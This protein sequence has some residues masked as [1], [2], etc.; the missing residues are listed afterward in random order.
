MIGRLCYIRFGNIPEI[1]FS[2]NWLKDKLEEG[3][4]CYEAVEREGVYS[5]LIPSLTGNT[6]VG[7][8]AVLDRPMYEIIGTLV[9]YGSDNEPLLLN[10][11]IIKEIFQ[12]RTSSGYG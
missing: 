10:P 11:N 12:E 9:G 1:G 7:L 8:S 2:K 4:S 3:V 5:I 6:C